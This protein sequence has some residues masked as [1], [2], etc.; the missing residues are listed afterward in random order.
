MV[1]ITKRQA[2]T[3]AF[4]AAT[5]PRSTNVA[6]AAH[7]EHSHAE[8]GEALSGDRSPPIAPAIHADGRAP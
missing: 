1:A 3:R 8:A 7:A 6:Y 2:R 5:V 4:S